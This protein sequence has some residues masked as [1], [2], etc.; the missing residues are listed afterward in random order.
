M[1]IN[2]IGPGP[3]LVNLCHRQFADNFGAINLMILDMPNKSFWRYITDA[4]CCYISHSAY[5]LDEGA[6]TLLSN[7]GASGSWCSRR[8]HHKSDIDNQIMAAMK[9]CDFEL[10]Q[11]WFY[12]LRCIWQMEKDCNE[13]TRNPN[14]SDRYWFAL[15]VV[16]NIVRC[17]EN[18]YEFSIYYFCVLFF[19]RPRQDYLYL[20]GTLQSNMWRKCLA[21][22][23]EYRNTEWINR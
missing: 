5:C 11:R 16:N 10:V 21:F 18:W 23:I 19:W 8:V 14:W 7:T 4:W 15:R 9:Y 12:G 6:D 13:Q 2:A 20:F 17:N 1:Y 3:A 22:H